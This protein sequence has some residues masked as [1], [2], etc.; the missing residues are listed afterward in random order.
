MKVQP[1][2]TDNGCIKK[3]QAAATVMGVGPAGNAI[4]GSNWSED[5]SYLSTFVPYTHPG[6]SPGPG[7]DSLNAASVRYIVDALGKL[8]SSGPRKVELWTWIRTELL[9]ATTE[10]MYGP[11]NPFRN[12]AFEEAW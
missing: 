2:Y 12:P 11:K 7:L 8:T 5:G 6:L 9:M 10:S 3:A 1:K 4:I